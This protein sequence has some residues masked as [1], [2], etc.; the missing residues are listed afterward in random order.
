MADEL[1]CQPIEQFGMRGRFAPGAE[2]V[3]SGDDAVSQQMLP[4]SIDDHAGDELAGPGL[5]IGHPI[6]EC[7]AA[8]RSPRAG[9]RMRGPVFFRIGRSHEH[10]QISKRG[11]ALFLI[12]IA[13]TQKEGL[14]E[15]IVPLTVKPDGRQSF[16]RHEHLDGFGP[17]RTE[18]KIDLTTHGCREGGEQAVVVGLGDRIEFVIVTAGTAHGEAQHGGPR[19]GQHVVQFVVALLFDFV[20]R[21]L[22]AVDA[23]GQKAGRHHRQAVVRGQFIAGQ[24]P[25]NKRVERQV[26][27]E[28]AN[29]EIAEV[30]GGRPIVI[31]LETVALGEAGKIEP[32]SGPP[33]P[34]MRTCQQPVEE[35]F[36][37][38]GRR[39]VHEGVDF[40]RR[41]RQ[42]DQ[43]ERHA[44]NEFAS[45]DLRIQPDFLF[46]QGLFDKRVDRRFAPFP[47]SPGTLSCFSGWNA[48]NCRAL[49]STVRPVQFGAGRRDGSN[50]SSYG[51]P[52]SIHSAIYAISASESFGAS[53]GMYG[54][55][56][57]LISRY[58]RLSAAFPSTTALPAVP[59]A[60]SPSRVARLNAD[61]TSASPP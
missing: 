31:V 9:R 36:V 15:E 22:R 35:S 27:I 7:R 23:G 32:V 14:L 17:F 38:Q 1:A 3:R 42:P 26:E 39:I 61:W 59:P 45:V 30:I 56:A 49:G 20:F 41:R 28:G 25:A 8:K 51:A 43:V 18:R 37:G 48:Q 55:S 6:R 2:I 46:R 60:K 12:H 52:R 24:L 53:C 19:R 47:A 50:D 5:R 34:V 16:A 10:L 29:H 57:C 40:S 58:S 44:S 13:A 33:M 4:Q 54:S 11:L 21:D